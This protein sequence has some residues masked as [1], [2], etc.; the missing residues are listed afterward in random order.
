MFESQEIQNIVLS[1]DKA[2]FTFD[3]AGYKGFTNQ[4]NNVKF[5]NKG[6]FSRVLYAILIIMR[7]TSKDMSCCL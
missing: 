5:Q 4:K 1:V 6:S 3:T 7:Y 2:R